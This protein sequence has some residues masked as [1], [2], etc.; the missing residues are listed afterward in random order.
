[1]YVPVQ[2][3][4]RP[5]T[6]KQITVCMA[7]TMFALTPIQ[8]GR[9]ADNGLR[10]LAV[11]L[12]GRHGRLVVAHRGIEWPTRRRCQRLSLSE[13][14]NP[15]RKEWKDTLNHLLHGSRALGLIRP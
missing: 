1:L 5:L 14:I 15:A 9:T 7:L 4:R 8:E 13:C 3:S 11:R 6:Y 10:E 12:Q 2:H